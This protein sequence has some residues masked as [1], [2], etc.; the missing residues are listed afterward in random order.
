MELYRA[1]ARG[2]TEKVER[3]LDQGANIEFTLFGWTPLM[4]ICSKSHMWD[5][6]SLDTVRLLLSRGSNIE[7]VDGGEKGL[8]RSLHLACQHGGHEGGAEV[9][10]ALLDAGAD[11]E[12]CSEDQWRPLHYAVFF[13]HDLVVEELLKRGADTTAMTMLGK[14]P[15]IIAK[16]KRMKSELY[17][18]KHTKILKR[19]RIIQMLLEKPHPSSSDA[20]YQLDPYYP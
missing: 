15:L 9:V 10:S 2:D 11:M 4:V 19:D 1:A 13:G 8:R 16:E 6:C 12:A 14:T 3:M 7:A 5:R 20:L 17:E 18:E